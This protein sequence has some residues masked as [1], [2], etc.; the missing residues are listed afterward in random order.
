M[1]TTNIHLG[2]SFLDRLVK[3]TYGVNSLGELNQ[4]QM[5]ELDSYMKTSDFTTKSSEFRTQD[6]NKFQGSMDLFM[7]K[8]YTPNAL[9][10]K[11]SLTNPNNTK[12]L[13]PRKTTTPTSPSVS[14]TPSPTPKLMSGTKAQNLSLAKQHGFQ[15]LDAVKEFQTKMGL[16]ATGE[17]N[18]DTLDRLLWYNTM[19]EKGYKE[20]SGSKGFYFNG[21]G[22]NYYYTND[23]NKYDYTTLPKA[24]HLSDFAKQNN[25][26]KKK[27]ENGTTYYRYNPTGVGDFYVDSKGNIYNAGAFGAIGPKLNA[28]S[29]FG[30]GYVQDQYNELRK[31]LS[32]YQKNGGVIK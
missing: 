10:Y 18:Q 15:S 29:K 4:D 7:N 24:F 17:L 32:M 9:L 20:G 26:T 6:R 2:E 21:S 25:L 28:Q 19:K 22:Y 11:Q 30:S 31:K 8:P 3:D 16:D 14:N 13:I 1:A 5:N 12:Y 23:K 27:V